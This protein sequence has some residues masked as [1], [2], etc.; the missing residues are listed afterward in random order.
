MKRIHSIG[1]TSKEQNKTKKCL[2]KHESPQIL[3]EHWEGMDLEWIP[4]II[5]YIIADN[6]EKCQENE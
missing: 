5:M 6:T 1:R 3:F 4:A 2:Q